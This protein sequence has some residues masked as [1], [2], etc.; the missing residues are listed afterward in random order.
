MK[1][2]LF[3]FKVGVGKCKFLVLTKKCIVLSDN[4]ILFLQ[5]LFI[6]LSNLLKI[7]FKQFDLPKVLKMVLF[8]EF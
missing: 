3:K 8:F 1:G 7:R 6:P 2:L 5:H 4:S